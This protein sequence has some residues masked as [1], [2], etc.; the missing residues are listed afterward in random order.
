M[1]LYI[2]IDIGK[3]FNYASF[4]NEKGVE[5]DKRFK[6]KNNYLG[7]LK[8][9]D[10]IDK[11]TYDYNFKYDDILIGFESTGH[12]WINIDWFITEKLNIKTVMVRN[13]AVRHTRALNS[14]GKGKNDSLDSRTIAE[15]LKNGYYFDVQGR[16]EDYIVLRRLTRERSELEKEIARY[17]NRFRAWL[18]VNNP[19]FLE[20]FSNVF[21]AG[22]LALLKVYP[23]PLD[24][25]KDSYLVVREKLREVGYSRTNKTLKIYYEEVETY[26]NIINGISY[27]DIL[28][29]S[30]YIEAL[31]MYMKKK[32][33]LDE[34]I[35]AL[36]NFL[37]G[38]V[39]TSLSE[40]KGM[41]KA[42]VASLIAEIG[43]INNFK[44]AIHL[45]SYAG[46]NLQGEGSG[47][48]K[49]HSWISK[50]GNRKIRKELYVITFN[51]V[52][53]NDYFRGLYCYYKSYKRPNEKSSKEMLI[54]L[55]CKLLRVVYGMLKYNVEFNLNEMLKNYDFRN[56]N[57]EKFIDEFLGNS[58]K[59]QKIIP[60]EIEDIFLNNRKS[61]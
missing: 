10:N 23:S 47:K 33:N 4:L 50:T 48:N 32:E 41:P 51:L 37:E 14:Q 52:R 54:A 13:D 58:E 7:F 44:S 56:I 31:E 40:I 35:E 38:K 28:E 2:G 11:L 57:K 43:N 19:I 3:E 36:M 27:A 6:F 59:K 60:Q 46:L 9:K 42:Q 55:M 8:L 20:N 1:N 17:K 49:G 15:C 24:I 22:A 53:H 30:E 34:R 5:I 61:N 25:I 21:S 18:D 26:K 12:Y 39:Y 29:I 45:I 16:K